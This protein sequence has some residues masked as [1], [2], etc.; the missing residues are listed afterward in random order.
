[1][2]PAQKQQAFSYAMY[3]A[4][5]AMSRGDKAAT[6]QWATRAAQIFP[7]QE[8]PWLLLAA[9]A[10]PQASIGYLKRALEINPKSEAARKGMHWAI[11]R[12]REQPAQTRPQPVRT[13]TPLA[14]TQPVPVPAA[15]HKVHVQ[16]ATPADLQR[17]RA[18]LVPWLL[19]FLFACLIA[20]A[21]ISTPQLS[22][23]FEAPRD[24]ALALVNIEKPTF[25]P[26]PT[27]TFT[28]TPTNT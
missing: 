21:W 3:E 10:N 9:V 15:R 25:T 5:K 24:F 14:A 13:A 8:P 2:T 6:R 22:Q 1:M 28:P 23:A 12:L 4:Q 17:P 11:K 18:V 26:T 19:L 7:N 20:F 16:R 27:A